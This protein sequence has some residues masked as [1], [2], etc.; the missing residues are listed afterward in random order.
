MEKKTD[1]KGERQ[2]IWEVKLFGVKINLLWAALYFLVVS[3]LWSEKFALLIMGA[4]LFHEYG[5]AWSMWRNGIKIKGMFFMPPLGLA[6]V[7]DSPMTSRKAEAEVGIMG[8]LWGLIMT[9][10]VW[11]VGAYTGNPM[12]QRMTA[13]VAFINLFNLVPLNPLDGGRIVKSVAYSYSPKLGLAVLI[14]GLILTVGLTVFYSP[15]VGAFVF[16]MGWLEFRQE[17]RSRQL[18]ADRKVIVDVLAEFLDRISFH[19]VGQPTARTGE[20]VAE[21]LARYYGG[22]DS[23]SPEQRE[24]RMA[25]L[26]TFSPDM[27]RRLA[28]NGCDYVDYCRAMPIILAQDALKALRHRIDL[29]AEPVVA[30]WI[31]EFQS[32]PFAETAMA[33]YLKIKELPLMDARAR[34][35]YGLAYLALVGLLFYVWRSHGGMPGMIE[36][37]QMLK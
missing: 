36:L 23:A 26:Q 20:A 13:F 12:I 31:M 16:F 14:I 22:L 3:W 17:L 28:E 34:A 35:L 30:A 18:L 15:L 4:L 29:G 37:L 32:R 10:V 11:A 24:Q 7:A 8:P 19:K 21:G 9:L 27:V 6:V 2:S 33:K 1:P 5:H 25:E